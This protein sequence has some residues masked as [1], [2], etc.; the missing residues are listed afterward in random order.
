MGWRY[1]PFHAGVSNKDGNET[2]YHSHMKDK[3]QETG[4]S[5]VAPKDLYGNDAYAVRMP[6][7]R[8]SKWILNEIRDREI[9]STP[10]IEHPFG[11]RVVMKL[12]IEGLEFKVFP[13][14]ITSGALCDT[15]HF[16]FGEF[17]SSVN[18]P[19]LFP[20]NITSDGKN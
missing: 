2:F 1:H 10:F 16:V 5:A 18:Y 8:L 9:P 15:V 12:D 19:N 20:M 4:F 11:P 7:V 6:T 17:H 3:E 14:L 13:D